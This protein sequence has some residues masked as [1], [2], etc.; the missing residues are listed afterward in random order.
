MKEIDGF[1]T[2]VGCD[3]SDLSRTQLESLGHVSMPILKIL[4]AKCKDCC[5]GSYSEVRYCTSTSCPLWPLR[6]GKNPLRESNE[7]DENRHAAL[8]ERGKKLAATR[9]KQQ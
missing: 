6:M 2:M 1:Q 3:P 4:R 8:V 9:H 5:G 7:V